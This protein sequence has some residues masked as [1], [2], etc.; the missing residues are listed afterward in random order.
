[1]ANKKLYY[2]RLIQL[3]VYLDYKKKKIEDPVFILDEGIVQYVSSLAFEDKI[4]FKSGLKRL[5]RKIVKEYNP[6]I[7]NYQISVET[8]YN[9]IMSRGKVNDRYYNNDPDH[10]KRLL[11]VKRQNIDLIINEFIDQFE[12]VDLTDPS[13]DPSELLVNTLGNYI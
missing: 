12:T 5:V 8:A 7:I 2:K 11:I 9:R 13:V 4:V 10:A 6:I 1:M 3:I